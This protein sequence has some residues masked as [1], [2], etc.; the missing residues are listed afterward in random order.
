MY[1]RATHQKRADGSVVTHLPLAESGWNP[2]KKRS[3]VRMVSHGGR[4]EDPQ[5][6]ER[7]RQWARSILTTCAPQELVEQDPQWRVLD[8]WPVGALDVLEAMWKR[9]GIPDV[10]S[11]PLAARQVDCAVERALL[12]MVANRACAPSS[13]R[14]CAEQGW[15]ADVR[16]DGTDALVVHH[17]YRAMAVREAHKEAMEPAWYCRLAD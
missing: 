15:R 9:L 8:T 2:H 13:T 1:W 7:L 4:A 12:A 10:I 16:I 14:S 17:L 11:A 3:E 5:T 6:A